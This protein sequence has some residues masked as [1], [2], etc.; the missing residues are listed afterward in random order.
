[1]IKFF[2]NIRQNLLSEGKTTKYLKYAI[3]QVT[4][5]IKG[6]LGTPISKLKT[7]SS[8]PGRGPRGGYYDEKN[9]TIQMAFDF[10]GKKQI[11]IKFK[12]QVQPKPT[13]SPSQE[14][15]TF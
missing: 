4:F 10:A 6:L 2:R 14:G 13:P 5:D 7:N 15:N 1:M 12:D 3:S 9:E 8:P 11:M